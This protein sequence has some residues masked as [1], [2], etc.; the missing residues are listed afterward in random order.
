[1][2]PARIRR[3]PTSVQMDNA[4]LTARPG[5]HLSIMMRSAM[6]RVAVVMESILASFALILITDARGRTIVIQNVLMT[7]LQIQI[8]LHMIQTNIVKAKMA[9][10]TQPAVMAIKRDLQML[11][12]VKPTLAQYIKQMFGEVQ[13]AKNILAC[14][15]PQWTINVIPNV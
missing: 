3:F 2:V 1:V 14:L 11:Q 4:M 10:S 8:G 9:S 7:L 15:Y 13:V 5:G 12:S 6:N